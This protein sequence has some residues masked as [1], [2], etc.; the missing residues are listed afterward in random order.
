MNECKGLKDYLTNTMNSFEK[1]RF[2]AHLKSCRQCADAVA[3]DL[4]ISKALFDIPKV[5][6]PA[7]FTGIVMREVVARKQSRLAWWGYGIAVVLIAALTG[8]V[9]GGNVPAVAGQAAAVIHSMADFGT[10]LYT[11]IHNISA[12]LFHT[13]PMGRM[14]PALAGGTFLALCFVFYKTALTHSSGRR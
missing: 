3:E 2:E 13:L 7:Q 4:A 9:L 6:V 8:I 1:K 5:N 10:S 14:S 12:V 11:I